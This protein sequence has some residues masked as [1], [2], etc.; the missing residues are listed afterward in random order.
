M[1]VLVF[2]VLVE[3][4]EGVGFHRKLKFAFC[5]GRIRRLVALSEAGMIRVVEYER[6]RT[7][8][9]VEER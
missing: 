9:F 1:V 4:G 2:K 7:R 3:E 5:G 6:H 8:S